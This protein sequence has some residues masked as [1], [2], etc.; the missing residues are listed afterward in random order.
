MSWL[1]SSIAFI[2]SFLLARIM[3]DSDI[4][5]GYLGYFLEKSHAD[6][7]SFIT[8][9]LFTSYIFS[10]FF[11]NTVVV[12]SMIPIVKIILDSVRDPAQ[13]KQVSTPIVLALIYGANIGGMGSLTGAPLNILTIGLIEG[14]QLPGRE[15]ITFFSW[16]LFGIPATFVLILISRMVLKTQEKN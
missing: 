7:S 12:L 10:V 4:H 1:Q 5:R 11:S 13:R 6:F 2:I 14:A 3:I 9:I 8:G 15:N 16:L